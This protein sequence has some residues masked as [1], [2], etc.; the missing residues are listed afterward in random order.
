MNSKTSLR[1]A[2]AITLFLLV[3]N[4]GLA[5]RNTRELQINTGWVEHTHQVITN[6]EGA[7]A[8]VTEAESGV[9]GF[10]I[11]GD[12]AQLSEVEP[13]LAK[14]GNNIDDVDRLTKDNLRQQEKLPE[15]RRRMDARVAILRKLVEM[16]KVD[17][18]EAVRQAMAGYRGKDEMDALRAV[19]V[20]MI[21][22]EE[23]NLLARRD[24]AEQT[25]RV[26]LVAGLSSGLLG[27]F[28]IIGGFWLVHRHLRQR[29]LAENTVSEYAERLRT[30]LASIG[31]GVITTDRSGL[32]TNLNAVAEH[33]TGWTTK[34]ALGK[35][36]E[37]VFKI[38]N[39][40]TREAV[41]NPAIRALKEGVIVGLANHTVLIAK[42]GSERPIDDSAAPIR[43]ANGEVVGCV[44]V[45]HDVSVRRTTERTLER[46]ERDL[47]DLFDNATIGIHWVGPDGTILRA[48][49]NELDMLGYTREEFVGRN[50]SEFHADEDVIVNILQ[51]LSS[52]E[53]LNDFPARLICKD[54][55]IKKVLINSNAFLED[56][57]FVHSRCFTRDVTAFELAQA[58]QSH[59]ASIV[60]AS[61][62]AIISKKL[63]GTI[64]SWN[65]G[66][67]RHFGYRAEQAIG[68][69]ISLLI[70]QDRL[71]E[72]ERIIARLKK[73]ER[74]D[75]YDTVRLRSDGTPIDVSLTISPIR[76]ASGEIIGASKFARD[77]TERKANERFLLESEERLRLALDA[78]R[79]GTWEW[80]IKENEVV[81]SPGLEKIHGLRPGSFDGTFEAYKNDI[82]PD[83]RER[84]LDA[85][86][87]TVTKGH[88]HH[89]EYRLLLADGTV[90]WV[91]GR[92]K[93]FYDDSGSPA[94][95]IG[96]CIDISER[97]KAE[98]QLRANEERLVRNSEVFRRLV[99]H[100][101]FGIYT[102]D[103]QFCL[104]QVSV[105]AQP[106][107]KNVRPLIGRDFAEAMR[108][109]WPEPLAT[110]LINT[111]RHTL[112]TGDSYLAPSLTAPR[113]DT[114]EVESYE[115]QIHRVTLPD[116][117][118]GV[119]CYYFDS[120]ALRQT[121]DELRRVAAN[122]SEAD[123][124][125][126]EFLAMLAHELR[127]PLAPIR[128]ALQI[129]RMTGPHGLNE[130]TDM[131]DR[132]LGQLVR[133]VD[134]LLDISRISSGKIELR[135]GKIELAS[136]I[137]HAVEASRPSCEAGGLEL[138]VT[139]PREAIY[140]NGDPTRL[141][142]VIG[143]LLN[144]SCKFTDSG[145][146]V[147]LI[148]RRENDE[149]VIVI[150]DTGIGIDPNEINSIFD[151][152]VQS[153]TS[154]KRTGSG[155]GIGLTLVKNLVEMHGGFVSASSEGFGHGTEFVV[156]LPILSEIA[157]PAAED[158]KTA[159][160]D[161]GVT[162]RRVLVVDD[163]V[164]SASSLE[165][166]LKLNGH[167]VRLAHDGLEAV[168]R[169]EEFLPD[170]ILLD[171]GLP[172]LNGYEAARRIRQADWGTNIVLIA[173]TGWGQEEDRQRS[174]EAGFDR[175]MVK[176]IEHSELTKI[177]EG[178]V[179][180]DGHKV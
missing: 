179:Q 169:A 58:A 7:L 25:Y 168:K 82:H 94:R 5:L 43:R 88:D 108:I 174:K 59:L 13:S 166:L 145:G 176:P 6:L 136:F 74:I 85:M 109:I 161:A 80:R 68:R 98:Q 50:I 4:I 30:T 102:V 97:K 14:I 95:M 124:R 171:I 18:L 54:G 158:R 70:P 40:S 81:W 167:D 106:A 89:T 151:M 100:S 62:D 72:E 46:S 83:D 44:L 22:H 39:E 73:G 148:V 93:L 47:R 67:E 132:Q 130:A 175:H 32:V 3:I 115:W 116:G 134:D 19:A 133:L 101:P 131:M 153:D 147:D 38:V 105:G 21:H 123:Q 146:V 164:D 159:D 61:E 149:V 10:L 49:Q 139:L 86:N 140:L 23:A 31:D 37:E 160:D 27:L 111:F 91:E 63:D 103:S 141:A 142:Q 71:D 79:M 20:D 177:L 76:D 120:T 33:L 78:G 24:Q 26:A 45:F 12:E 84:M 52:G 90:R 117:Q 60:E 36:L 173:L 8:E 65:A 53:T 55:S 154:L 113:G 157:R 114:D 156:R 15:L 99:E 64:T 163:N 29:E 121:E 1:A 135:T 51:L 77:I 178:L 66:A 112:D 129:V 162:K 34:E 155:L 128:N 57:N 11:S 126:N 96:V 138:R 170:V 92:G 180:R 41:V 9:R 125:K 69:H 28:A 127:N 2:A 48:N 172:K 144:N 104:H 56:G 150:R 118:L 143:N 16:R 107:F 87:E 119:V 42:D 75:H 17:S 35:P 122:L 165:M 137:N 152:F 110:E